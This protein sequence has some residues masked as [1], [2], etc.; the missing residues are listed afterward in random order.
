ML[1]GTRLARAS[2]LRCGH[3][4]VLTPWGRHT[5]CRPLRSPD[6]A[7]S[8]IGARSFA[9]LRAGEPYRREVRP[10][11]LRETT[12]QARRPSQRPRNPHSPGQRG[13][14][15]RCH[16]RAARARSCSKCLRGQPP[17]SYEWRICGRRTLVE[18]ECDQQAQLDRPSSESWLST[19]GVSSRWSRFNRNGTCCL[20]GEG[21]RGQH[22]RQTAPLVLRRRTPSAHK[23]D[24]EFC[25][26]LPWQ[27]VIVFS[28]R[29]RREIGDLVAVV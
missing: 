1:G 2:G 9:V 16:R 27:S 20:Y 4:T 8:A 3:A 18:P 5:V 23:R 29:S 24:E 11:A 22:K 26:S 28:E 10:R 17:R 14:Q 13:H 19:I 7:S 6:G 12:F 21:A 15:A 25:L